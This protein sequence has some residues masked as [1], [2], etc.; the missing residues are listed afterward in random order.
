M[1]AYFLTSLPKTTG[2]IY[3]NDLFNTWPESAIEE[4]IEKIKSTEE[5]LRY[6]AMIGNLK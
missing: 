2:G 4:Y 1:A 6:I 3:D 5:D